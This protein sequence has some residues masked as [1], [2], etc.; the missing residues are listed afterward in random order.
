MKK[1]L[2]FFCAISVVFC[3][4]AV[5]SAIPITFTYTSDNTIVAAWYQQDGASPQ[6]LSLGPNSNNW[7]LADTATIGPLAGHPY[8]IIWQC[9]NS[10]SPSDGNPG[11][12]LGE[13]SVSPDFTVASLL[14]S[15]QW[16]VAFV[17]NMTPPSDFDTLTWL[18][19]TEYG[20][21]GSANIWGTNYGTIT[22]ISTNAQWIWTQHN[23]ADQDAPATG[24]SV[25]V[26]LELTPTPTITPEP[27]TFL[28]LALGMLGFVGI[29]RRKKISYSKNVI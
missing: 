6:A 25:Y 27:S 15:A 10:G 23:F 17:N 18:S 21:N 2:S 24:N 8:Q 14:S 22:G 9:E 12:F 3:F 26:K 29:I 4:S 16:E 19:A 13:M 11:G 5:C 20:T 1:L 7:T 28:L